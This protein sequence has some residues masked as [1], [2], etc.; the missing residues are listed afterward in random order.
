MPTRT[1]TTCSSTSTWA[2]C[3]RPSLSGRTLSGGGRPGRGRRLD[4]VAA[5]RLGGVQRA[6]AGGEQR[7][8]GRAR[9]GGARH[10]GADGAPQGP[11]GH[12][13]LPPPA[14]GADR[15]G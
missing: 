1:V 14:G 6:V 4:P 15:L 7:R 10:A 8:R 2:T 11:A 12:L 5:G 13:V 9:G 3:A